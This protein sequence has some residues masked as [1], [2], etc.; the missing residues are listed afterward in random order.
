MAGHAAIADA[1][2]TLRRARKRFLERGDPDS[3]HDLRVALRRLRA[4]LTLF[5]PILVLPHRL[6][7][8]ELQRLGRDLADLRDQDVAL[9]AMAALPALDDKARYRLQRRARRRER[10]ARRVAGRLRGARVRSMLRALRRWNQSPAFRVDEDTPASVLLPG[11]RSRVAVIELHPA[12]CLTLQ[13]DAAGT[14]H[15]LDTIYDDDTTAELLH[16]LRRRLKQVRYQLEV[17]ARVF[18]GDWSLPLERLRLL[19][20]SLGVMQDVRVLGP[21]AVVPRDRVRAASAAWDEL[22]GE[23]LGRLREVLDGR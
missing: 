4:V 20:E 1:A 7:D 12:W 17:I 16:E 22:R 8:R 23:R 11:M 6:G 13:P 15:A 10:E 18:A 5:R 21:L 3:L 9:E 14:L 19:Q 2:R